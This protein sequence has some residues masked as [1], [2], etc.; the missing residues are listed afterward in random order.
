MRGRGVLPNAHLATIDERKLTRYLLASE[1]PAGRAKAAFFRRFEFDAATLRDALLS[2]ARVSPA[3]LAAET[4]FGA[5]YVIE[6]VLLSPDGR[7]P[8][9]RA[10]WFIERDE[11]APRLVTAY[12]LP[13][14][15]R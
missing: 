8:G 9:V 3:H 10:I 11:L 5:K 13:E 15:E 1:H 2:Q 4:R 6:G 14:T 12:A 7:R